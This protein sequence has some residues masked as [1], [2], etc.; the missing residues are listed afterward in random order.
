M[1]EHREKEEGGGEKE[2]GGREMERHRET[3]GGDQD[4][5]AVLSAG[6]TQGPG[7]AQHTWAAPGSGPLGEPVASGLV[8]EWDGSCLPPS[9]GLGIMCHLWKQG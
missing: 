4:I 5:P 6:G 7:P 8:G 9:L 2:E 3:G 1:W